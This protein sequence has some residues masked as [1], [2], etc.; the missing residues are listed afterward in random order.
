LKNQPHLPR[1]VELLFLAVLVIG[2][3]VLV[4]RDENQFWQEAALPVAFIAVVVGWRW[5]RKRGGS[6]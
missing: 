2:A 1:S 3:V 4:I 6:P 5:W